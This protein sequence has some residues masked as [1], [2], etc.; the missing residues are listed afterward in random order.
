MT[1]LL[2]A[3]GGIVLLLG[4]AVLIGVSMDTEAQRRVWKQVA[5]ERRAFREER[6]RAVSEPAARCADCPRRR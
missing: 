3:A 1:A 2:V 6:L 4:F 5:R